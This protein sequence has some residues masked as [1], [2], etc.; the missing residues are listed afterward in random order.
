MRLPTRLSSLPRSVLAIALIITGTG[1]LTSQDAIMKLLSGHHSVWALIFLRSCVSLLVLRLAVAIAKQGSPL[2]VRRLGGQYLRGVLLFL[3]FT[4]YYAAISAMPL[5][6]VTAIFYLAPVLATG[7]SALILKERVG[8]RLWIAV[9]IGFAGAVVMVRPGGDMFQGAAWLALAAACAYALAIILTR[10]LGSTESSVSM[11]YYSLLVYL[12]FTGVGV[13]CIELLA[14]SGA[15]QLNLTRGW[16]D[17]GL[18]ELGL[19]ALAGAAVALGTVCLAQ[20]YRMAVVAVNVPFEYSAF[21]WAGALGYL[22]WGDVPSSHTLLGAS[23]VV[24]AG[25]YVLRHEAARIRRQVPA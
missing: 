23:L 17:P 7:L 24:G 15:Q 22:F 13:T 25:L 21:I 5:L 12:A 6:E 8:P 20:A 3:T 18:A 10:H 19:L 2:E 14:P 11:S 4:C 9:A 16:T 1:A